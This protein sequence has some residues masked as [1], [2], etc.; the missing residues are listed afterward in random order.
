VET[1]KLKMVG[2]TKKRLQDV[3]ADEKERI[4]Q[5]VS[6]YCETSPTGTNTTTGQIRRIDEVL[7]SSR[8]LQ[9]TRVVQWDLAP[10]MDILPVVSSLS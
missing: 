7:D 9:S 2:K 8:V 4:V 6:H 5:A 1:K 10:Y 3:I